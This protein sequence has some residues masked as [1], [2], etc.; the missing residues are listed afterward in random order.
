MPLYENVLPP[1]GLLPLPVLRE[2]VDVLRD[3]RA[4]GY[5]VVDAKPDNFVQDPREG[6]KIV[7][8]EFAYP[9]SGAEELLERG[10]EFVAPAPGRY[11][12]VP[13]GDSSYEVRWLPRTGMPLAVL[14]DATPWSQRLHRARYRLR[15][16]TISPGSPM[17]ASLKRA[18]RT[19]GRLR[20]VASSL[21]GRRA[22]G[23]PPGQEQPW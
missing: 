4:H 10:P 15:T 6:L 7:D 21:R 16:L 5:V 22:W 20:P 18:R 14:L 8:L 13:A 11:Q 2:M 17:R 1:S 3:I 12:E 23:R 9:V 19:I